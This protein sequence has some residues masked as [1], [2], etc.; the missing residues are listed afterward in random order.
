MIVLA[1]GAGVGIVFLVVSRVTDESFGIRGQYTDPDHGRFPWILE[2]PF[3]ACRSIFHGGPFFN[4]HA[5]QEEISQKI[6]ISFCTVSYGCIYRR[7]DHW[8]ILNRTE[9][10]KGITVKS[11]VKACS[12]GKHSR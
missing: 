10:R 8:R 9:E 11:I 7:D 12:K 1:A 3:P 2:Y 6:S 5:A 4:I